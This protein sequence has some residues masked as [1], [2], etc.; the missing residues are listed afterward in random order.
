MN[1]FGTS[2]CTRV[3]GRSAY[4]RIMAATDGLSSKTV[5]DF[6]GV[7]VVTNSFA[8]E[9]FG[10]MAHDMGFDGIRSMTSFTNIDAFTAKVVRRVIDARSKEFELVTA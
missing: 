7:T 3:S 5:F 8:D 10:R 1:E 2:L 4:D 9:V 6:S